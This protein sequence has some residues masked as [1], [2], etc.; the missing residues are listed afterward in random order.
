[1]AAGRLLGRLTATPLKVEGLHNIPKTGAFVLVANHSSFLD[2]LV[3]VAILPRR[4]SFVAKREL[5]A[6]FVARVFLDSLGTEYVERFDMQRS[7]DDA[8][9][10]VRA[11][12]QGRPVGFFPEG[13]FIRMSGLLPFRLGAF[14]AAAEAGVPVVPI[15]IRGTR[16][17]VPAETAFPRHGAISVIVG[18]PI[19]PQGQDWSAAIA[20]RDAARTEILDRSGEPDLVR[21]APSL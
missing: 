9:R 7:A 6:N 2:G 3:L 19:F 20:L 4:V 1:G 5:G 13:T 12:Q 17:I 21:S 18:A 16:A 11:V 15:T 14:A 10:L 8:R